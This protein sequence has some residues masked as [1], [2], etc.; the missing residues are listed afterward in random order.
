MLPRVEDC[1][2][3]YPLSTEPSTHPLT[4]YGVGN[5]LNLFPGTQ[6]I[7]KN[8]GYRHPQTHGGGSSCTWVQTTDFVVVLSHECGRKSLLAVA[9]KP[10]GELSKRTR[11]LLAIESA[12][13]LA[14]G[15]EW[16]LFTPDLFA[17]QVKKSLEQISPWTRE[18]LP[19]LMLQT[20]ASLT[21]AHS[22]LA[23]LDLLQ[24]L[25]ARFGSRDVSQR[26]LWQSVWH[27]FLPIDLAHQWR[28]SRPLRLIGQSEFLQLNPVA[29]RRSSWTS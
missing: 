6:D 9:V 8:L 28:P 10:R 4:R 22:H 7:A 19:D 1:L 24:V 18:S 15:A 23:Y 13:W 29:A 3:Q 5:P 17:P 27:G 11:Q 14:R 2:E 20:A 12:Y 21:R 25:D 16:L 26:A